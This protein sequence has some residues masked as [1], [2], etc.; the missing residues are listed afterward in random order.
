MIHGTAIQRDLEKW[1]QKNCMKFNKGK[2]EVLKLEVKVS[3]HQ[4]MLL[5]TQLENTSSGQDFGIP[6]DKLNT[7]HPHGKKKNPV[8]SQAALG[9]LPAGLRR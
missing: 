8:I 1:G 2:C 7:E 4:Y 5:D 3:M 9:A 6:A